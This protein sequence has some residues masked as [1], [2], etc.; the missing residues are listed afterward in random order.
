MRETPIADFT[1]WRHR[2]VTVCE[3]QA[4][5]TCT[6]GIVILLH[7]AQQRLC[8]SSN[9]LFF[10]AAL[11][12]QHQPHAAA[13]M[14]LAILQLIY[15][16]LCEL[17]SQQWIQYSTLSLPRNLL[18]IHSLRAALYTKLC[19]RWLDNCIKLNLIT[20]S[21]YFTVTVPLRPRA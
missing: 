16:Q 15:I 13:A 4:A 18:G 21:S 9:Y 11:G 12:M 17:Q 2:N 1:V 8:Y 20:N 14:V 3:E 6:A 19:Y 10:R 7:G 5:S